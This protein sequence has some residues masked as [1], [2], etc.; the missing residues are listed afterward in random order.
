MAERVIVNDLY[1]GLFPNGDIPSLK[2]IQERIT[3]KNFTV[4]DAI[5]LKAYNDGMIFGEM[6]DITANKNVVEMLQD[7]F[8]RGKSEGNCKC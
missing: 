2:E 6:A 1:E 8:P 5:I 3:G 4:R 7:K